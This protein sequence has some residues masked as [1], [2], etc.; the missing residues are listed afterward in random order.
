MRRPRGP[1]RTDV[2]RPRGG[3]PPVA[4]HGRRGTLLLVGSPPSCR[5]PSHAAA[6]PPEAEGSLR[7][8]RLSNL[9][10]PDALQRMERRR[11]SA[12]PRWGV[13]ISSCSQRPTMPLEPGKYGM[14]TN[15]P[16]RLRKRMVVLLMHPLVVPGAQRRTH[17]PPWHSAFGPHGMSMRRQVPETTAEKGWME[18]PRRREGCEAFRADALIRMPPLARAV[19]P[20]EG[21]LRAHGITPR[22]GPRVLPQTRARPR[23]ACARMGEKDHRRR[24]QRRQ[25]PRHRHRSAAFPRAATGPPEGAH[26]ASRSFRETSVWAVLA[27]SGRAWSRSACWGAPGMP[28][29]ARRV[30]PNAGT[31]G[32]PSLYSA[33]RARSPRWGSFFAAF[34]RRWGR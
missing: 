3:S 2:G 13:Y 22:P 14:G 29:A 4:R 10:A 6:A 25:A 21:P 17:W 24:W 1:A 30:I 34:E 16:S 20:G 28:K 23:R 18:R 19:L 26:F 15:A 5:P 31:L 12:A 33:G 9:P 8:R 11:G 27:N 7:A 32:A